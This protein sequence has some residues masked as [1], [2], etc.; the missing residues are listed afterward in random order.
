MAYWGTSRRR[1]V[2]LGL[3]L[4]IVLVWG[5]P[6]ARAATISFDLSIEYSGGTEPEGAAPWLRASFVDSVVDDEVILTLSTP[7]LTDAECVKE[8]GF[9]LN[10]NYNS[11]NLVFSAPSKTGSFDNPTIT[12]G[13]NHFLAD[14]DGYFDIK[15]LFSQ[16][17]GSSARFGVGDGVVY[18]ISGIVGLTAG[19]FDVISA[20][21]GGAG[22]YKTVAH[23]R[24]I[25]A[26]DDDSGWVAPEPATL[27]LL[28]IGSLVLLRKRRT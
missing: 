18:T 10:T 11:A 13:T 9:N 24:A 6:A 25:G 23:V 26:E 14:G 15:I 4:F 7:N 5:T 28:L 21:N 2:W 8:W 27:G 1:G 20:P 16:A 22:E 17:D 12:T 3:V 19:W